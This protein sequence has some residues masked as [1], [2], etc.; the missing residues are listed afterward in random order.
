MTACDTHGYVSIGGDRVDETSSQHRWRGARVLQ[1]SGFRPS[2]LSPAGEGS[3]LGRQN[4]PQPWNWLSTQPSYGA[5]AVVARAIG[6]EDGQGE[7]VTS[8]EQLDDILKNYPGLV[9][10]DVYTTWCG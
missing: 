7:Q 3:P 6:K 2:L 5:N 1:P 9:V 10:L 8:E 4:R